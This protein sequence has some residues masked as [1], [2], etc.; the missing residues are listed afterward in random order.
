M[1]R[2][3]IPTWGQEE[4]Y[5]ERWGRW[6]TGWRRSSASPPLQPQIFRTV[7]WM[8]C[9]VALN[10]AVMGTVVTAVGCRGHSGQGV[11]AVLDTGGLGCV[12]SWSRP[13]SVSRTQCSKPCGL[14]WTQCSKPC[15][16]SWTQC[17]KPCGLS[18]TQC[19]RP[20]D[21]SWSMPC[22]P[23]CTVVRPC[24]KRT[25]TEVRV[26]NVHMIKVMWPTLTL[27][28]MLLSTWTSRSRPR[29]YH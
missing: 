29:G 5:E 12:L 6:R 28:P 23:S 7:W 2:G 14:S 27:C 3:I 19:S 1:E 21:L 24:A 18:W 26:W 13:C 25:L 11:V 15:G 9:Y 22:D 17:S 10:K 20:C 8:K 4:I 16:L